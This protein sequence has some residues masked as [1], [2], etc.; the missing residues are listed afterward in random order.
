MKKRQRHGA[1]RIGPDMIPPGS[2]DPSQR[3]RS[4]ATISR[5]LPV[6]ILCAAAGAALE[7][8]PSSNEISW[9]TF[10]H[11]LEEAATT[12]KSMYIDLY[13][14]WCAPCKTMDRVTFSNDSV[15]AILNDAYVPVRIDIDT[16]QYTDSLKTAWKL[17][18]VPTGIILASNG[19]E[20]KRKIG[21][22]SS[23]ELIRWLDPSADDLFGNWK[24]FEEARRDAVSG[25]KPL[26]VL[27]SMEPGSR[28]VL[29][30]LRADSAF[31]QYLQQTYVP[32]RLAAYDSTFHWIDT[33]RAIAPL[34]YPSSGVLLVAL[35]NDLKI[36]GQVALFPGMH[37]NAEAYLRSLNTPR[38]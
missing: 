27:V 26:L 31:I 30:Q 18:G 16:D 24:S 12:G 35:T 28:G 13:A 32:T 17:R 4:T 21:F 38:R 11:G 20:V 23:T 14:T 34:E 10:A 33:L 36:E 22:Q 5:L 37:E 7:W 1:H 15:R 19:Q 2:K 6:A 25:G 8:W 29:E 9:R 3:Q